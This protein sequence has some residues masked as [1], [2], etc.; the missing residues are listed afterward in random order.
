MVSIFHQYICPTLIYSISVRVLFISIHRYENGD[1]WPYLKEGDYTYT[2][3]D[4]AKGFNINIP[5][6]EVCT[7]EADF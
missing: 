3:G 1:E 4:V 5:L 7:S 2:G 6:N